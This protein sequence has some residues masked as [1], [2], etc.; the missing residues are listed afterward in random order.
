MV[1]LDKND[2]SGHEGHGE[3]D[4]QDPHVERLR[5]DPAAPPH[6]VF[7]LVGLLGNSERPGYKRLYF[8]AALDH[9][10]EI[11][12]DDILHRALIDPAHPP[13]I[14]LNST[15][16]TVK[17]SAVIDYVRSAVA[18]AFD[19]FDID[20]Q[21]G[22]GA[23]SSGLH[24]LTFPPAN[25]NPPHTQGQGPGCQQ[26]VSDQQTI[27]LPTCI[28]CNTQCGQ[29]TCNTC[30]TNCDQ[31]T[32]H[33]CT[34]NTQC[35]QNTCVNTQCG[36]DCALNNPTAPANCVPTPGPTRPPCITANCG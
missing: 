29:N 27:C 23:R 2:T 35:H 24:P 30:N 33:T 22:P 3:L 21:V 31:N 26:N 4:R 28:S 13:F 19:D 17:R 32:C 8:S 7:T 25:Q 12:T 6:R 20:I 18:D 1:E 16:L 5:P 14:G 34:C 36:V 11:R 10:A 9:Y 15:R